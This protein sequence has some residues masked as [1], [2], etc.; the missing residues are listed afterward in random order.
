MLGEAEVQIVLGAKGARMSSAS[1]AK[2]V[3]EP[4]EV[5][6]G[7]KDFELVGFCSGLCCI[8]GAFWRLF[9]VALGTMTFERALGALGASEAAAREKFIDVGN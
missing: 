9:S 6:V 7:A 4:G 5:P 3:D 2:A 8:F 1:R